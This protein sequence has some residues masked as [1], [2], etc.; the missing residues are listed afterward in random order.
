MV[1]VVIPTLNE[2]ANI[3]Q[4]LDCV[5]NQT[6]WPLETIVVDGGSTD[7]TAEYALAFKQVMPM[8]VF[9]HRD[10][11]C[12]K[13][14]NFGASMAKGDVLLFLGADV[15]IP[16]DT[17]AKIEKVFESNSRLIAMTGL[18]IP[19]GTTPLCKIEYLLYYGLAKIFN[20][21]RLRFVANNTFFAIQRDAFIKLGGFPYVDNPDCLFANS[22][23][24]RQTA[25]KTDI[26]YYVSGRRYNHLGFAGFNRYYNFCVENFLPWMHRLTIREKDTPEKV[27]ARHQEKKDVIVGWP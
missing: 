8:R 11:I 27:F 5:Y 6:R 26:L 19:F 12:P 22:V 2:R 18:A 17:I 4:I 14:Q 3:R 10:E 20:E 23:P 16:D 21:A 9:M 24:I 1:S 25:F 7:E 13:S 15:I